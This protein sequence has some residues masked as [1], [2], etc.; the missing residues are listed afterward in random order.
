M[1]PTAREARYSGQISE[2]V[3]T[4]FHIVLMTLK[5]VSPCDLIP[6]EG[7]EGRIAITIRQ[8]CDKIYNRLFQS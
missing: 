7:V 3:V 1:S 8:Q 5:L 2:S 6:V 4:G